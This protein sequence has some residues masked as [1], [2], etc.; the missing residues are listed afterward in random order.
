[1]YSIMGGLVEINDTLRISKEQGFPA[2]LDIEKHKIHPFK[3]EDFK[4]KIFTFVNKPNIRLYP[5]YPIRCFLVEDID[6]K[7]LYWGLCQIIEVN[8]DYVKQTSS[9]K[10]KITYLNTFYN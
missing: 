5:V 1:M 10:Y 7:W 4:D 6:G 8:L 2:A 3:A 9:G